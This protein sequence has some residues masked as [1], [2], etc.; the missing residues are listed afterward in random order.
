MMIRRVLSALT[1][2]AT[3]CMLAYPLTVVAQ[4]AGREETDLAPSAFTAG[5]GGLGALLML[6]NPTV[7]RARLRITDRV[8]WF[9]EEPVASQSAHL[10]VLQHDFSV[11]FPLWQDRTHEWS[12][13][14]SVRS[15][16]FDMH[17]RLLDTGPAFPEDLWHV[18]FG[19]TSRHQ[20][21]NGWIGSGM[22]SV[23]S[24]S[25]HPFAS[26]NDLSVGG[27]ISLRVPQGQCNAW[28]FSLAYAP[29]SELPFPIP[30]VA[31]VYRPSERLSAVIGLP[32]YLLYR[33]WDTLTLEGSYMLL[34][35]VH[36]R[37]T[38]RLGA[39]VR[40]FAGFDWAN[41]SY[42]LADRLDDEDRFFAY[43]K[44]VTTGAQLA[45]GRHMALNFAG[46]Y[47]FD[48][49]YFEGENYSDRDRNRVDVDAGPFASV[50][51][52]VRWRG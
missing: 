43:D 16:F 45:L 44:R 10:S 38:Y 27:S 29:T 15:T 4:E 19:T 34:R 48:R 35:T 5:R 6:L 41:D 7:G 51:L 32:I 21:A 18:R 37:A 12:A 14:A 3:V 46:G 1:A 17:V 47:A 39:P 36:V 49:F 11:A 22:L 40:R 23:G 30:G 2:L 28:L 8:T 31:Y 9:P 20:F 13:S 52:Q 33:P 25:D 42:R 26:L 50:Q 24:D